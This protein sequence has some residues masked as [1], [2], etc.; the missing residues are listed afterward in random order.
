MHKVAIG[1]FQEMWAYV[2][3]MEKGTT[4]KNIMVFWVF[5]FMQF[6]CYIYWEI[7]MTDYY[8]IEKDKA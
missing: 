7:L 1:M 5:V 2:K 8:L 4:N 3:L 6:A